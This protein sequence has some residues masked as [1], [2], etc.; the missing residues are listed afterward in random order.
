MGNKNEKVVG[1]NGVLGR[2]KCIYQ[3]ICISIRPLLFIV[4][5][6]LMF[7]DFLLFFFISAIL[8]MECQAG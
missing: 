7:I 6:V 2:S 5:M 1:V 3:R 4:G 8:D